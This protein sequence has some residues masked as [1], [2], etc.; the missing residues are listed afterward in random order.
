MLARSDAQRGS[1]P[2][3]AREVEE[4]H[5]EKLIA[6]GP[7]LE[8]TNDELLDPIVDR[9]YEMMDLAGLIP[10]PPEE[11]QGVDLKVEY[12][13][14]LAQAQKL[15]GV[16]GQDRFMQS[17]LSMVELFPSVRHKIKTNEVVDIYA[18]LLGV[19]PKQIR[20][21]DEADGLAAEEAK[22]Q[23]AQAEAEQAKN[24]ASAISQAGNTPMGGDTALSRLADGAGETAE[25]ATE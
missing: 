20:S 10:P 4:R 17:A 18:D 6:L 24:M 5:E 11:L 13:S 3:T 23:A 19:D 15:V 25:G 1:T 21:N 14:I 22:A 9:V 12:I 2:V 8:R 16:V 7:V